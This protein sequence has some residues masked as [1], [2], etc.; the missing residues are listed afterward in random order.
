MHAYCGT[1]VL[2]LG[3]E[4]PRESNER[5]EALVLQHTGRS[6]ILLEN[7]SQTT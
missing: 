7:R 3:A 5:S 1:G 2:L 4:E 6:T